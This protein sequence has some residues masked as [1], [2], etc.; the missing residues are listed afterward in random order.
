MKLPKA[1]EIVELNIKEAGP[2]MPPDCLAALKLCCGAAKRVN[3]IREWGDE[4]AG[5]LLP[6]ETNEKSP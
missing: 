3:A 5:E 4:P 2:K 1:I 6:G